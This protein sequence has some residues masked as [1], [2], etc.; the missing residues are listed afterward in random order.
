MKKGL[1]SVGVFAIL[2]C[3]SPTEPLDVVA[4]PPSLKLTNPSEVSV[5]YFIVERGYA[6]R[7]NWGP[8]TNPRTCVGI[9]P[10][11]TRSVPYTSIGGYAPD[12]QE[13]IVY[14]WHLTPRLGGQFEPDSIRAVVVQL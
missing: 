13:A 5:Y 1:V 10:N 7:I 2:A 11:A 4:A 14:W 8:C 12:A 3:S 6:A 9:P